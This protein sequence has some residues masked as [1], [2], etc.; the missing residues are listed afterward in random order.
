MRTERDILGELSLPDDCLW[1]INTER[2]RLNFQISSFTLPFGFIQAIALIKKHYALANSQ[3]GNLNQDVAK[4]ISLAAAEIWEGKL[5][6]QFPLDVF[7]T[8]SATSTNM[9][10]NEVVSN[11]AKQIYREQYG[12]EPVIHPNDHVN[13]GQSSNDVVP[14]AIGLATL[15]AFRNKLSPALQQI[16]AAL[17]KKEK[18]F[19]KVIKLGRTHLQDAVP[20]TVGQ[21]ISGWRTQ[22]KWAFDQLTV[23][24]NELHKVPLG[25]TAVGTGVN[26]SKEV[27]ESV[28]EGLRKDLGIHIVATENNFASQSNVNVFY[29]FSAGISRLCLA[30]LKFLND[31]RFLSSGPLGGYAEYRIPSIQAGSSIMPG[32]INPVALESASMVCFFCLGLHQSVAFSETVSNFQLNTAL[33]LVAFCLLTQI[34]VLA[35]SLRN[36]REKVI[37]GLDVDEGRCFMLAQSS[38]SLATPLTRV[39]GYDLTAKVV[40]HAV[41]KRSPIKQAVMELGLNVPNLDELLDLKNFI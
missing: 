35:N 10:V 38:P 29:S 8:G 30:L 33:P 16:I 6:D 5:A 1:G 15:I 32:K 22:I 20:L 25:G 7:Q 41:E 2:A 19:S 18:Q 17:E 40:K 14:S 21:E 12:N 13:L 11:R 26:C 36:L 24:S 27:V 31:L 3:H 37:E 9:N 4:A 34:E 23:I 39:I 28:L